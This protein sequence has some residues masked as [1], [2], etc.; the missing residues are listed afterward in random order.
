MNHIASWVL[1][2]SIIAPVSTRADSAKPSA[3]D[4]IL[5]T[6]PYD[7]D[8]V[9]D[10]T[11]GV[12]AALLF[13]AMAAYSGE[14]PFSAHCA[15]LGSGR[16]DPDDLF[17][18][19]RYAV[20]KSSTAWD[21][22]SN[23]AELTAI[24]GPLAFDGLDVLFSHSTAPWSDWGTDVLVMAQAQLT[25]GIANYG[26]KLSVGRPRPRQYRSNT[27][28]AVAESELSFPSGHTVAISAGATAF[29]YTYWLRNPSSSSRYWVALACGALSLSGGWARV[30]AG[31]HFPTDVVAG[32]ALGAMSGVLVPWLHR[33][34]ELGGATLVPAVTSDSASASLIWRL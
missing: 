22:Y 19:D 29:A 3:P 33:R 30:E 5:R 8:A 28:K 25:A 10:T 17:G 9:V 21:Q 1:A 4:G 15:R 24:L 32:L 27:Y 14:Q 23:I 12:G 18:I 2:L 20:G 34:E 16:C 13:G 26:L 11:Y 7:I 31:K 6:T